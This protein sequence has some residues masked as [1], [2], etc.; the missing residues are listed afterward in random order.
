MWPKITSSGVRCAQDVHYGART[1]YTHSI[2]AKYAREVR[3]FAQ[4]SHRIQRHV[5]GM[6]DFSRAWH[7]R[8]PRKSCAQFTRERRAPK[9][10]ILLAT[11]V[12]A[13]LDVTG[14]LPAHMLHWCWTVAKYCVWLCKWSPFKVLISPIFVGVTRF[15]TDRLEDVWQ[16]ERLSLLSTDLFG[17]ELS[18]W[19]H[20]QGRGRHY[21]I[22]DVWRNW[23]VHLAGDISR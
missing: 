15:C 7:T 18:T 11:S 3:G 13:F 10:V 23:W 1:S 6:R 14:A 19:R 2:C 9:D 4:H 17:W 22:R 12:R 20:I 21:P 16:N 5:R 8:I